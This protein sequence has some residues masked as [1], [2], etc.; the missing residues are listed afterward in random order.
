MIM[1]F[2]K[3]NLKDPVGKEEERLLAVKTYLVTNHSKR[4]QT[5]TNLLVVG[6]CECGNESSGV[7]AVSY[8]VCI[9][10]IYPWDKA[11]RA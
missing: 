7:H 8:S 2:R 3:H 6:P 11:A 9:L 10:G 5:W 4:P 1:Y